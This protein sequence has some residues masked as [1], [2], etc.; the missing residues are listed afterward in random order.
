MAKK[1]TAKK[2][3]KKKTAKKTTKKA[4]KKS[5]PPVTHSTSKPSKEKYKKPT[6]GI[7]IAALILNLLILPGLGTLIAGRNRTGAWQLVLFLVGIPLI[8][9]FVGIIMMLVAWI[10]GILT[11]V[12]LIRESEA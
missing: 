1:K 7:A 6:Q 9:I 5:S 8:L 4:V 10:W 11:G 2:T 3:T 12:Q